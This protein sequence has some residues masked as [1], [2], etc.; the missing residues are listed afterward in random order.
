MIVETRE[1]VDKL[2]M[3]NRNIIR[4]KEVLKTENQAMKGRNFKNF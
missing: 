3:R 4:E 1:T 2:L